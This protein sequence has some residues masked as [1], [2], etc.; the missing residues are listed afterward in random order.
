MFETP[1]F[2]VAEMM[3]EDSED[4]E[5]GGLSDLGGRGC[6][7]KVLESLA[8]KFRVF[9]AVRFRAMHTHVCVWVVLD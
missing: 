8:G 6:E 2:D 1:R 5:G 4:E 3:K 7:V 9:G